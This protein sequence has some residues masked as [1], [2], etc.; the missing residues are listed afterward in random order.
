MDGIV[1]FVQNF[2]DQSVNNYSKAAPK[3]KVEKW[4]YCVALEKAGYKATCEIAEGSK[5]LWFIWSKEGE[6]EIRVRLSF[7]E[8]QMWLN[9]LEKRSAKEKN[10]DNDDERER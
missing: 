1:R 3:K 5:D 9:Y 4:K 2:V 8:Q 10:N 6:E 7:V